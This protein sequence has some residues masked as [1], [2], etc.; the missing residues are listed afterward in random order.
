MVNVSL[1]WKVLQMQFL[2]LASLISFKKFDTIRE[3]RFLPG[4]A[5]TVCSRLIKLVI[6][7]DIC[8][9][10]KVLQMQFLQVGSLTSLKRFD[11]IREYLT[12][13]RL[14][15]GGG[16]EGGQFAGCAKRVCSR[17]IK[18]VIMVDIS[19]GWKVLQMHFLQFAS[20]INL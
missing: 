15:G 14:G 18:V 17:L 2:Q 20:L 13:F 8:L 5:K 4:F 19:L 1:G 16:G 9:G 11:T 10:W 3:Y 7:V 12:Q 6:M